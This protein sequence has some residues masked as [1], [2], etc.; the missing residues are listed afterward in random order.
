MAKNCSPETFEEEVQK[1]LTKYAEEINDRMDEVVND[2]GK[3]A[4][5]LLKA[6][7]PVDAGAPKGGDYAKGWKLEKSGKAHRQLTHSATVYNKHAGLV[8]LLEHGHALRQGGRSPAKVHVKP[9]EDML[10][11]NFRPEDLTR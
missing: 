5:K 10:Y 9:V 2:L 8:H 1:I 7:S 11:E 4:V 6:T 3:E